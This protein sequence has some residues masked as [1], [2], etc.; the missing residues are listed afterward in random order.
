M[1]VCPICNDRIQS[2]ILEEH[3][4][5]CLE[6]SMQQEEDIPRRTRRHGGNDNTIAGI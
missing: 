3:V 2:A 5:E 1:G 6:R 4:N